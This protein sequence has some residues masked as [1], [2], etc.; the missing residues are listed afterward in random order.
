MNK[1]QAYIRK[2]DTKIKNTFKKIVIKK[3]NDNIFHVKKVL[4]EEIL[5]FIV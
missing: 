5:F 3:F 1:V 2:G 4:K